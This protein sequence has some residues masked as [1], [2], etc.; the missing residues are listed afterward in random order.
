M[1]NLK[2][3]S[4]LVLSFGFFIASCSSASA[5]E[6]AISQLNNNTFHILGNNQCAYQSFVATQNNIS[7]VD[8]KLDGF[9]QS[10]YFVGY[11]DVRDTN[12]NEYQPFQFLSSTNLQSDNIAWG[13]GN[14]YHFSFNGATTIGNTYY[15]KL[16][17]VSGGGIAPL[18]QNGNPY[19]SG[20]WWIGTGVFS[21]E[22][23]WFKI[24][25]EKPQFILKSGCTNPVVVSFPDQP[26][27]FT[28]YCGTDLYYKPTDNNFVLSKVSYSYYSCDLV[29]GSLIGQQCTANSFFE[30][31][32]VDISNYLFIRQTD[33]SMLVNGMELTAF[34]DSLPLFVAPSPTIQDAGVG[35]IATT[36]QLLKDYLPQILALFAG[37][38]VSMV[39]V[40]RILPK[41]LK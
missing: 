34:V 39:F 37:W 15:I 24:Y 2:I 14:I 4:F 33:P 21:Q 5:S 41:F 12:N 31:E 1:K 7:G 18:S 13:V 35:Y 25:Y 27:N 9:G 29:G 17:Q 20:N 16:C 8:L 32:N 11:T 3:Y 28:V 23:L 6:V 22:D 26:D 38:F 10:T 36:S 40:L 30:E 19:D